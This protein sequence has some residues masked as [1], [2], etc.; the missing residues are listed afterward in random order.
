MHFNRLEDVFEEEATKKFGAKVVAPSIKGKK[1]YHLTPLL[2]L[3]HVGCVPPAESRHVDGL[4]AFN[5]VTLP[6]GK[7]CFWRKL[8]ASF[9]DKIDR[10]FPFIHT[11]TAQSK[12]FNYP[13]SSIS[14]FDW[15]FLAKLFGSGVAN[16]VSSPSLPLVFPSNDPDPF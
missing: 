5:K 13:S 6:V 16:P 14:L 2:D 9:L 15:T 8:W 1:M 12:S 4:E 10:E 7:V 3:D 11:G